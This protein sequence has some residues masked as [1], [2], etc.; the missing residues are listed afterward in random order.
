MRMR[1]RNCLRRSRYDPKLCKTVLGIVRYVTQI[2]MVWC[3]PQ[4]VQQEQNNREDSKN[5]IQQTAERL[6]SKPTIS[7]PNSETIR[8]RLDILLTR[9]DILRADVATRTRGVESKLK[10]VSEFL[11]D[12]EE[13]SSWASTTRELL[14]KQDSGGYNQEVVDPKVCYV[15]PLLEARS[16]QLTT[17]S[18]LDAP[19]WCAF[20]N[21]PPVFIRKWLVLSKSVIVSHELYPYWKV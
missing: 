10:R 20:I 16:F 8:T 9:W 12:L 14:E 19:R 2:L 1:W 11:G 21:H 17:R 7:K 4:G 13:L 3:F 5:S 18:I 15:N 6:L